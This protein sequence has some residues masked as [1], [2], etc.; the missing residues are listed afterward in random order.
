MILPQRFMA[1]G[2]TEG[3]HIYELR[4]FL[5]L[6]PGI[7]EDID[8]IKPLR[9]DAGSTPHTRPGG[10]TSFAGECQM[11]LCVGLVALAVLSEKE[12]SCK[13]EHACK[14]KDNGT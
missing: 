11:V 1:K 8:L 2:K 14:T 10:E 4:N 7:K 3:T 9:N 6:L 5:T 12:R 13:L